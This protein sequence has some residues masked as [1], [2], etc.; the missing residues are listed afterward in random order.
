MLSVETKVL[1]CAL[2]GKSPA[3]FPHNNMYYFADCA[4]TA[5]EIRPLFY[6]L[7]SL[8]AKIANKYFQ[9]L[10]FF[11]ANKDESNHRL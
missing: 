2:K 3:I 4:G 9:D 11:C 10:L 7:P 1:L 6:P 5:S 8:V